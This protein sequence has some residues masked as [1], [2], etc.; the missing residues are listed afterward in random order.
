MSNFCS[1][2][3]T[4]FLQFKKFDWIKY[5]QHTKS[6]Y[7]IYNQFLNNVAQVPWYVCPSMAATA[8]ALPSPLAAPEQICRGEKSF[9]Y[10]LY[11]IQILIDAMFG[12]CSHFYGKI[13][14]LFFV[15][16]GKTTVVLVSEKC[17]K[18]QIWIRYPVLE[19]Y[20]NPCGLGTE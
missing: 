1:A 4:T 12:Q 14:S 13:K 5:G 2:R 6:N 16:I 15:R 8:I 11:S 10:P 18:R 3:M 19:F 17:T 20:N 9:Y 7:K